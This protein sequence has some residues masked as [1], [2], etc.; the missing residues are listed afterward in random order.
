MSSLEE[1]VR[2]FYGKNF[3]YD[4]KEF[5]V[6]DVSVVDNRAVIR[7]DKRSF[8]YYES[9]FEMFLNSCV[10]VQNKRAEKARIANYPVVVNE[11]KPD[12]P[13][14]STTV[15]NASKVNEKLM[16]MFDTI[17]QNPTK[18]N[19]DK[20]DAMVRVSDAMVKNELIRLRF[21]TIK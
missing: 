6:A 21:L 16:E 10:F 7:T 14:I 12:I 8:V 9:E 15:K 5:K 1:K 3:R 11:V 2:E 19:I 4:G 17:C 13:E 20:A 18:E